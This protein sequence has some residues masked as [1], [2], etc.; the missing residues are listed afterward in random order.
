[1]AEPVHDDEPK[2]PPGRPVGAINGRSK[3]ALTILQDEYGLDPVRA[4]AELCIKQVPMTNSKGEVQFDPEGNPYMVPFL[5]GSEM[6][7]ALGKLADKTYPTLAAQK[8]DLGVGNLPTVL[9]DMRGVQED[10]REGI[11]V[12]YEDHSDDAEFEEAPEP[13]SVA[14]EPESVHTPPTTKSH[15]ARRMRG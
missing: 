13:Q 9:M 10:P 2:R 4:L 12:D 8:I 1:M 3:R 14:S 6:T 5:S 7:T 11:D 15:R